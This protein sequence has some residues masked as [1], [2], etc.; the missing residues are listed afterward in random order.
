[1]GNFVHLHVH[2]EY[3]LLDGLAK[4]DKLLEKAKQN[5]MESLALTDHGAMYGAI[6]FYAAAKEKGI[7]PILGVEI[8]MA[9]RSR[10]D[11]QANIDSDRYHLILLAKNNTGYKNLLKLVSAAHLEGFYYRPRIDMEILRENAEGLIA[12]SACIEGEISQLLLKGEE[13]KAEQ[14][15]KEFL[16]IFGKDFYLEI[17]RHPKIKDQE[18]ANQ[19]IIKLSRKLGIPL[20]A[21]NDI[22]YV[23]PDDAEAQDVLLAIQTQ[24][25][26]TDKDRLTMIDSPDFYFRSSKEMET[27]FKD[28]P[29]SLK[30]TLK[31]AQQ[32]QIDISFGNWILPN[33]PLPEGKTADEYLKELVY[34]RLKS[35]F[36]NPSEEII[37]RI[38]YE[39]EVIN[40]KGFSTYFLI[41]QDLVNWAKSQGIRV[42]PGRGSAAGSLVSYVLRITSIDPIKHNLPFERFLNP[43]RPSPPDIDLDFADDRRDEVIDYITQ[44]YGQDKVAQIV[45]FNVM[46]A[47]EAV[48]DVG[49]VL[50]MPYSEPDKVAKLIPPGMKIAEALNNVPELATLYKEPK[51][52]KLLDLSMKIEGT[53]RHASTHAAGVIIGDKPLIEYVPLQKET[54][55][56]KLMTQ[57]DM[58]CLDIN[59]AGPEKAI[60]LL[61]IDI[62]GLRNLTILE[63]ALEFIKTT[64]GKKIDLS[65]IP[66]D[67]KPTFKMIAAGETTGVF[68]LESAGMRRLA[69]KLNPS[70]FSDLSAM[71]ALFRPGPMQFIDEFI[72]GKKNPQKI[73]YPHPDLKP[74]LEE[75]YGIAVYQEQC[76]QIANVMAGY[77][78]GEADMLRRAIGKKKKEIM[79]EEKKKFIRQAIQKGYSKQVVEKVFA[80][81]ERF[82]SYGFNKAHSTSYAMIAYQTAYLKT[83]FPVEFMAALLTTEA[84]GSSGPTKD[85]KIALAVDECRRIGIVVLPP[86]INKSQAGFTIEN[87]P[88]SLN[89]RAI[90]FG[91]SAIKNVGEAAIKAILKAREKGGKFKSLFDF[92]QRVDG[93]KVNKKVLESLIKVGAMDQFGKR[94]ALLSALDRIREKAL[95][96]QKEKNNGQVS[97]FGNDPQTTVS[98]RDDL[99]EVE[100]FSREELLSLEKELL[101]FYLTDHP[102]S[103]VLENLNSLR[104]HR[105]FQIDKNEHQ[106][107]KIR[108][109][110]LISDI[111]I[112]STRK[113]NQE[114]AF[115]RIQ[116]ET[117]SLEA[118]VFPRVFKESKHYWQKE[119][120]VLVD[121]VVEYREEKLSLLVERVRAPEEA[122][123]FQSE[124]STSGVDFEIRIPARISPQKLIKLNNILKENRGEKRG[125]LVFY[126][127]ES[128]KRM[129]LSYGVDYNPSLE[130]EIRKILGET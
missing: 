37:K 34:E 117:G 33:Y 48:R 30:N 112:V 118:V 76:L 106:K 40:Q 12:T 107:Q 120:I 8:Y 93:Q 9:A 130:K 1:M 70:R 75:T 58:Y 63:K 50:G 46:K 10:F 64:Q 18:V 55:G 4:I 29:E 22:H 74:I 60:G 15:A 92:C 73:N 104:T 85:E 124:N 41:V 14:K 90:R 5:G 103:S 91:F 84:S 61:K 36:S 23:E 49:R 67:D 57:Y 129:T 83:H 110:G 66:L 13:E 2:S 62:L 21:T 59:A 45:T 116:D 86:D 128:E 38:D 108:I 28:Y 56:D 111:R 35:R 119:K 47:R 51:Y 80:L 101:G 26:I 94:A 96:I 7:K 39:L 77:S 126:N 113:S 44:K 32:C 24:K 27:L 11:K 53:V 81:I 123:G 95:N 109:G 71:V 52:K 19:K 88:S 78:L 79:A 54:R 127:G 82:A 68:Q 16:D 72:Y 89:G 65:E 98:F 17:Q 122:A 105:I 3:S 25:K 20:V 115:V 6:K 69:R 87:E 31:I 97:L 99:P 121:G 114:M 43:Q 100:D 42:G 125:V 102:L